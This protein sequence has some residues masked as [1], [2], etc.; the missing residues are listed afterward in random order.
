MVSIE[1]LVREF[2]DAYGRDPDVIVSA[3]GRL[4]FLNTH[5]DYKGLPVVGAA[6]NLRTYVALSSRSDSIASIYSINLRREGLDY[7]DIFDMSRASI[8]GGKWFGDYIRSLTMV[9]RMRGYGVSGFNMMIYSDVPMGSGLGSSAALLVASLGGLNELFMLGLSVRDMAEISFEAEHDVMKIPCGRLDQ[10][11][12]AYGGFIVLRTRPPYDVETLQLGAIF[13]VIDSGIRHSTADIHPRRQ[14]ELNMAIERLRLIIDRPDL[15]EILGENYYETRWDYMDEHHIAH[16][17]ERLEPRLRNRVLYTLRAHRSTLAAL[18][19]L[20]RGHIDLEKL[21]EALR[22]ERE[23]VENFVGRYRDRLKA[24]IGLIMLYQH[25]LLSELYEV[26]LEA[27]DRL[28]DLA[29]SMGS[30]G[31]KLSGAGLGGAVIAMVPS[32]DIGEEIIREAISRGLA[33]SGWV[34]NIDEGVRVESS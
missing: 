15:L 10:Y 8:I 1:A 26:S 28:V 32:R 18:E 21:S 5:Q 16:Y 4:D 2:K 9:L 33:S 14:A 11:S 24:S 17:I 19:I 13:A 34:V 29:M 27:L 20:R 3:P 7:K 30:Y 23:Y 25:R 22:L 12:S 31:A 6:V